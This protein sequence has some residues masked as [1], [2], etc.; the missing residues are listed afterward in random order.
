MKHVM[1]KLVLST[2][3]A[4]ISV[5]TW[6]AELEEVLVTAQKRTGKPAGCSHLCRRH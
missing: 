3:V 5:G 2:A 1:S 4:A 6:A